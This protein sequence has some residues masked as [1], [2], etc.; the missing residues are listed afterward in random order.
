M[1]QLLQEFQQLLA[2]L[3]A[4]LLFTLGQKFYHLLQFHAHHAFDLAVINGGLELFLAQGVV[5]QI[6]GELEEVYL[7][8]FVVFGRLFDDFVGLGVHKGF[9]LE[10]PGFHLRQYLTIFLI[11]TLH[12]G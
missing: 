1:P 6:V 2:V 12:F 9:N 10:L 5:P 4:F 3:V 11:I 8:V 7:Q